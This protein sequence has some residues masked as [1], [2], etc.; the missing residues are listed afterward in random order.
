MTISI[1]K[2]SKVRELQTLTI[3]ELDAI[4]RS[5]SY[6]NHGD[7]ILNREF[8][9]NVLVARWKKINGKLVCSWISVN[10]NQ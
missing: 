1:D 4:S 3:N 9:K 5:A 2:L 6:R 8:G 10:R 7:D